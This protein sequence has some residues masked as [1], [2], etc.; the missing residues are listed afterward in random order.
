M[1][2]FTV[3]RYLDR[4]TQALE[5]RDRWECLD[6]GY[7]ARPVVRQ[8]GDDCLQSR[9][10]EHW[11]K[12]LESAIED[13]SPYEDDPEWT[14]HCQSMINFLT[15]LVAAIPDWVLPEERQTLKDWIA[16]YQDFIAKAQTEAAQELALTA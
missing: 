9:T 7:C 5:R 2:E 14:N 12:S 6:Y 8:P 3:D 4:L 13:A 16:E 1:T 15:D 11:C 10:W